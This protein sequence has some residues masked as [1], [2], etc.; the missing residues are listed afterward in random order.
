M[1]PPERIAAARAYTSGDLP[2]IGRLACPCVSGGG[3]I[4]ASLRA[5]AV[6]VGTLGVMSDD[7]KPMVHI[8]I[9]RAGEGWKIDIGLPKE[10]LADLR[11]QGR[12]QVSGFSDDENAPGIE[13]EV[14]DMPV[15]PGLH[16]VAELWI[17]R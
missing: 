3:L 8:H 17:N 11:D 14:I 10:V 16:E 9:S 5:P 12:V 4:P 6:G 15:S 7:D 13:L 1:A 2:D